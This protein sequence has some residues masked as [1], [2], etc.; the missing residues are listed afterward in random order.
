VRAVVADSPAAVIAKILSF[1]SNEE[2]AHFV[3]YGCGHGK[4]L[5]QVAQALPQVQCVGVDIDS[6]IL[7]VARRRVS[8]ASLDN[9]VLCQ[10]D[11]FDHIDRLEDLAYLYLGGALNQR[12]GLALLASGRGRRLVAA[13]YPIIGAVSTA[14]LSRDP[15][16]WVYDVADQEHSVEW[17]GAITHLALPP[18]CRYLMS[19]AIRV[20]V[21]R[22]LTLRQRVLNGHADVSIRSYEFGLSPAQ[23]GVPLICDI[24]IECPPTVASHQT[25]FQIWVVAD[26]VELQPA[27]TIVVTPTAGQSPAEKLVQELTERTDLDPKSATLV[28][29]DGAGDFAS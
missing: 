27:H 22:E 17:D 7:A 10:G 2:P 14:R 18:G 28:Q 11:V 15:A 12:L 29:Q 1:C 6:E 26:G 20:T 4:L 13:R 25:V 24:L 21:K 5:V 19:R 3:D 9:I 8:E 23:P 16:I